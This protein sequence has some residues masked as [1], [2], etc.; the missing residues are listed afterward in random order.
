MA[1]LLKKRPQDGGAPAPG[2]PSGGAG[3]PRP[4]AGPMPG[5]AGP[6][7]GS[8]PR[9]GAGAPGEAPPGEEESNVSPE[10]QAE[11]EQFVTNG[12]QLMYSEELMDQILQNIEGKGNPVEGLATSAAMLVMRL[13]D[14]AEEQDREISP[15][16]KFH[17]G[18]ELLEQMAELAQEAGIHEYS[19][20]EIESAYYLA[21]DTYRAT[22]QEQGKLDMDEI[23]QDMEQLVQADQQGRLDELVPGASA[24]AE[25]APNPEGLAQQQQQQQ[26]M[27]GTPDQG[28]PRR[29]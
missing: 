15:D 3:A 23:N 4:G 24:Y 22:R 1:G 18:S 28:R 12:M 20:E 7:P 14:S 5:A 9:P 25:R 11:Y 2:P 19:D 16:V 6:P 10:E 13:E 21:L 8:A 26:P 17:G 27:G 29:G